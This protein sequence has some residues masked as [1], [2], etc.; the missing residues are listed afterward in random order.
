MQD[1]FRFRPPAA[2]GGAGPPGE[3]FHKCQIATPAEQGAVA[4]HA[5]ANPARP[6]APSPTAAPS[7]LASFNSTATVMRFIATQQVHVNG[8]VKL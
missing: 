3:A 4:M 7:A 8:A 1:L 6:A 2:R 5:P